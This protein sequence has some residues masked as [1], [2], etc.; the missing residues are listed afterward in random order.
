VQG[1]GHKGFMPNDNTSESNHSN[2][3][4]R[5]GDSHQTVHGMAFLDP[6]GVED[7]I[8]TGSV[9]AEFM[10]AQLITR[11]LVAGA[12]V[13]VLMAV[14][15]AAQDP[16]VPTTTA[17][18]ENR[19]PSSTNSLKSEVSGHPGQAQP[20]T[21]SPTSVDEVLKMMEAGVSKE[22]IKVYVENARSDYIP[23]AQ[24]LITL[25]QHGVPDEITTTLVNRS[26]EMR[27]QTN[28]TGAAV[29]PPMGL[30]GGEPDPEGYTYFQRYYLF[31]RTLGYVY[32]RLSLNYAPGFPSYYSINQPFGPGYGYVGHFVRPGAWFPS[33][34]AMFTPH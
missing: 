6:Q 26:A 19:A 1:S 12:V 2:N 23:T 28:P 24:D 10:S 31:P 15:V 17:E 5:A 21:Q 29:M 4:R 30:G 14:C 8:E 3:S 25:K 32:D 11:K 27:A 34:P 16:P 13:T 18:T 33:H 7:N 22:V 20:T 9:G